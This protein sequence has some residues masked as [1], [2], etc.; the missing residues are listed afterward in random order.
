MIQW[1]EY[2]QAN[3]EIC[4]DHVT[5]ETPFGRFKI[6]WKGWKQFDCPTVDETP[7]GDYFGSFYDVEEAKESCEKEYE[8]RLRQALG[9][10]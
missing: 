7:W 4:Y 3:S 6:T 8:E 2:R 10:K 9:N 1:S 5:A